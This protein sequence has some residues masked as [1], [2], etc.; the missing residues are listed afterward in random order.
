MPRKKIVKPLTMEQHA[1]NLARKHIQAVAFR[2]SNQLVEIEWNM[3]GVLGLDG[4]YF[5]RFVNKR[6]KIPA[7]YLESA[8]RS[9]CRLVRN[10]T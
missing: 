6:A 8:E 3:D 1:A 7:K 10:E 4:G 5:V 9:G 2:K